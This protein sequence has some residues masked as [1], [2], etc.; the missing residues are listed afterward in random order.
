MQYDEHVLVWRRYWD[1]IYCRRVF[2]ENLEYG[3]LP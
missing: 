2:A 1:N 3:G